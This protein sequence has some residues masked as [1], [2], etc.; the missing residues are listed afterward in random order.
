MVLTSSIPTQTRIVLWTPRA[1]SQSELAQLRLK[2]CL[3]QHR[4]SGGR[5]VAAVRVPQF[6]FPDPS[7]WSETAVSL[8]NTERQIP[9]AVGL[10]RALHP[11][12]GTSGRPSRKYKTAP[13]TIQRSIPGS[14]PAQFLA[15]C[16]VD[17]CFGNLDFE[18]MTFRRFQM[19]SCGFLITGLWLQSKK[20]LWL[21]WKLKKRCR[22]CRARIWFR[23]WS[24][25]SRE[26]R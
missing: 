9:P 6:G 14:S 4:F 8:R 23:P 1:A 7:L 26:T 15:E 22:R 10:D 5:A 11:L 16:G 19:A 12:L 21:G 3:L 13:S 17:F 2:V 24:G 20:I 18:G 25:S